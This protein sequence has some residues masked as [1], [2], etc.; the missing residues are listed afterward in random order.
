MKSIKIAMT[1]V[2][3]SAAST[4]FA[5][6]PTSI[7]FEANGETA[8]ATPFSQY[9]VKCSNG[10]KVQLTAWDNRRQWCVGQ[11]SSENC[12]KKQIKA[13]KAACKAS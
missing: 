4:S 7:V 8:E 11:E 5:A 12:A 6:K 13:A 1:A 3:L 2:L 9:A 10:K